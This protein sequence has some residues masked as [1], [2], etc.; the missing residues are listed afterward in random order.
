MW[1]N[2]DLNWAGWL[3]MSLGMA[4]FWVLV[5][6]LVLVAIKAGSSTGD[7]TRDARQILDQ[8]LA[9]GEIDIEEYQARRAVLP[10]A[11]R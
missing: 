1:W 10:D 6:G 9:R 4:G 8:R 7:L 3:L 11:R 5:A 2:H